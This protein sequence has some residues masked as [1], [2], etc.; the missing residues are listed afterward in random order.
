[1][2]EEPENSGPRPS[3][4]TR[5]PNKSTGNL[6]SGILA[7]RFASSWLHE[8]LWAQRP[9]DEIF[10]IT[11]SDK[12]W[13]NLE[14]RDRAFA[15][16]MVLT[17]LRH[18]GELD[19]VLS[20]F[21]DRTP[22]P[23]SGIMEILLVGAAQL[24]F[25]DGAP[26]AVIDL[27]VTQAKSSDKSRHMAKLVNAVL[28]RVSEKGRAI[29]DEDGAASSLRNIPKFAQKRW[30]SQYGDEIAGKIMKAVLTPP[31]LDL[32]VKENKDA[33]AEALGAT[34]LMFDCLRLN[35]KGMI[36]ALPGFDEG[37]W[38]VQDFAAHI[39]VKLMGD[40]RGKRVAD[41]C[42]APGGKTAALITAGA[43]VTAIDIS[44][45]R[46]E[47]LN[48]NLERLKLTANVMAADVLEF[49]PT[50]DA[51]GLF[52]AVLLDAPCSS[53]GTIR[54]HPDVIYLKTVKGILKQAALQRSL[55]K[56]AINFIKPGGFLLYCTCSLEREEGENQISGFVNEHPEIERMPFTL[57]EVAGQSHWLTKHGDVRLL[58]F[59]S[60]LAQNDDET[61]QK[62]AENAEDSRI[63][64]M[65]GFFISR[66]Q[67]L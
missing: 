45:K 23:R 57:D 34:S 50:E 59:Y 17:T 42:A 60:P 61:G 3:S 18:K 9:L 13:V 28:R 14:P 6:S 30:K 27:A 26:H 51:S 58:P 66:L 7:R 48:E 37:D 31:A 49:D 64:G 35:V 54:R 43:D 33:Q 24:L 52:D 46:L 21:L 15:R 62:I 53:T 11:E 36:T 63:T 44:E 22:Q 39:P 25:M 8:V 65:D 41:L 12:A 67:R 5:Q 56:K 19:F 2:S 16:A 1:M 38:W 29:L 10:A 40:V 4:K 20:H 47:R 55:L 32:I